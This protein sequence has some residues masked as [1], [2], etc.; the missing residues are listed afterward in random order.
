MNN[1]LQKLDQKPTQELTELTQRI[2]LLHSEALAG[3]KIGLDKAIEVGGLLTYAKKKIIPYGQFGEFC[4]MLPFTERTAQNYMR[5]YANRNLAK[6]E[7]LSDLNVFYEFLK[8][9]LAPEPES[10][11][12]LEAES[13]EASETSTEDTEQEEF[14]PTTA[15]VSFSKATHEPIR[16]ITVTENDEES[17]ESTQLRDEIQQKVQRL[18]NAVKALNDTLKQQPTENFDFEKSNLDLDIRSM[19]GS[20]FRFIAK[21]TEDTDGKKTL[22]D[23]ADSVRIAYQFW[24]LD[25]AKEEYHQDLDNA[26]T[27]EAQE[28]AMEKYDQRIAEAKA[29][30]AQDE[31]IDGE[32]VSAE[33]E[34][35]KEQAE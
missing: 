8:V 34:K 16:T 32:I 13:I 3:F 20:L 14:Q 12:P 23:L 24:N 35:A 4:K 7:S 17:E 26:E 2:T 11:A 9:S 10:I 6:T 22:A 1:A 18:N 30:K 33:T 19:I 21:S 25:K 5:V 15:Q 28:K 29:H 27:Q 31:A